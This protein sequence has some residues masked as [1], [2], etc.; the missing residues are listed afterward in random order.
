MPAEGEV[1]NYVQLPGDRVLAYEVCGDPHG[2]PVFLLHGTPGSRS[3]PRPRGIHLDLMGIRLITYDRPGYGESD[4]V[5]G[6]QVVDAA[7]DVMALA[8]ELGIERFA[9]LGRSGGAPH[10]LA[11]AAR[12]TDHVT[13][14][15]ALVSLAPRDAEGLDWFDGMVESNVREYRTACRASDGGAGGDESNRLLT[16]MLCRNTSNLMTSASSFLQSVLASVMP[17]TD[18]RVIS[19]PGIRASIVETYRYAVGS[20]KNL[21][22]PHGT[23]HAPTTVNGAGRLLLGWLDDTLAFCRDWGF[24]PDE[25]KVPV[26]LWHGREDVFSPVSHSEWLAERIPDATLVVEPGAAHF[27]SLQV[28]PEALQWGDRSR[29]TVVV[30]LAHRLE[31]LLAQCLGPGSVAILVQRHGEVRRTGQGVGMHLTQHPPVAVQGPLQ[32]V[33]CPLEVARLGHHVGEVH[34]AGQRGG[35]VVAEHDG[36]PRVGVGGDDFGGRPV[37]CLP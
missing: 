17:D 22:S 19:D 11:C 16:S 26:L 27:R 10:A 36:H 30:H 34:G 28:L 15:A 4:R 7:D 6:R 31:H 25:I 2:A 37:A 14:A 3:G 29:V 5:E 13:C 9:V 35:V 24:G 8:E 1:T 12:L 32:K 23:S 18:R 20:A 21:E 33:A